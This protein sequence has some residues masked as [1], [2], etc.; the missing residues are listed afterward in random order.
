MEDELRSAGKRFIYIYIYIEDK[1]LTLLKK[2]YVGIFLM[3]TFDVWN[4]PNLKWYDSLMTSD[5]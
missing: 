5:L 2:D 1:W 3:F 4:W